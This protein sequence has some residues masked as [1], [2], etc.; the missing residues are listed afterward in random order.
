MADMQDEG[1]RAL[2]EARNH[3]VVSTHN[4]DGSIHSAV[5]WVDLV[6][7]RPAVN[8]AVGR[9]W[10]THLERDPSITLLV[11]DE[12]NPFEYVEVR[13]T[14]EGTT[15]GADAHIDRLAEKYLDQDRYPYHQEGEQRITYVVTPSR[16]RHQVQ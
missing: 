1:V 5:V 15:D 6:D 11:Y 16:V 7:G 12:K 8:S 14:A 4:G 9:A 13:G 3:A 2:F 10:P